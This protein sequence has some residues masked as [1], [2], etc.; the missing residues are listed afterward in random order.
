MEK[1]EVLGLYGY[2]I[3]MSSVYSSGGEMLP[4]TALLLPKLFVSQV[5]SDSREGYVALQVAG[6][7]QKKKNVG[8]SV[9]GHFRAFDT[10][11]IPSLV[12]EVKAAGNAGASIGQEVSLAGGLV[13]GMRLKVSGVSKGKGFAGVVRRYG[14][15]GGP[16]SHG[17]KFHRQPGSSGQRTWPGR[18]MPGKRFPGHLGGKR[19]TVKNLEVVSWDDENRVLFVKG[20][21]PGARNSVVELARD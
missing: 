11:G 20:A 4:V 3:G 21:V 16:A 7:F 8:R 13:G 10:L 19:T 12:G 5:K 6:D 15:A 17:S 18:I 1:V 14:F 2:K 9:L